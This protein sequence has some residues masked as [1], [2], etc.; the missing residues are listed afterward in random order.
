MQ[1]ISDGNT[2]MH[3]QPGYCKRNFVYQGVERFLMN[4]FE[5]N[6][7]EKTIF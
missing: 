3:L 6:G 2:V 4:W 7:F 1:R 5:E